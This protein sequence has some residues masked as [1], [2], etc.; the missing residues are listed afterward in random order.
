VFKAPSWARFPVSLDGPKGSPFGTRCLRATA[1][2]RCLVARRSTESVHGGA[3]FGR[4]V[5]GLDP[6]P[7]Y[8]ALPPTGW[9]KRV[10][11]RDASVRRPLLARTRYDHLL[12]TR[13]DHLLATSGRCG[14]TAFICRSG[15]VHLPRR[16]RANR[17]SL[18]PASPMW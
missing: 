3:A 14:R 13:Y 16:R 15:H 7:A 5:D 10:P 1:L 17:S 4:Y 18:S 11:F 8:L 2:Y 9:P 12:A 6:Q